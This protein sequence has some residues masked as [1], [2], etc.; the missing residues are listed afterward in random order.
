[1]VAGR[2]VTCYPR[3]VDVGYALLRPLLFRTDPE[4]AHRWALRAA[5]A[6]GRDPVLRGL[7]EDHYAPELNPRLQVRAM[8]LRFAH[9]LGLAAGLDK[10]GEAIEAWAALGFAFLE[11]GTVTP[12]DGQDGNE[13]PRLARLPQH[14]AVVNRLGFPNR[15][16]PALAR[17]LREKKTDIPV[18]ANVGKARGTPLEEALEDFAGCAVII[19]HDRWFLDRIATHILAF[20]GDS[21]AVWFE[22]NYEEYHADLKR[23]LG[24]EADQPHRIKYKP[25]VR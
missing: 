16:A 2:G 13:G 17:R 6:M 4:R 14:R 8:G 10:D 5:A 3:R 9:P 25:L 23:R 15:G 24:D 18:G 12:G 1:M 20:E 22:G 7:L 19:S 21:Q 11:L